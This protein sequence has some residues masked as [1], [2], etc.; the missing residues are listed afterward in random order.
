MD[1]ALLIRV[2]RALRAPIDGKDV[3]IGT[4]YPIGDERVLVARHVLADQERPIDLGDIELTWFY[5]P[6][7]NGKRVRADPLKIELVW[8]G[9]DDWDAAIIKCPFP[10]GVRFPGDLLRCTPP[11]TDER[12]VSRGFAA[13]GWR[14]DGQEPQPLKGSTYECAADDS[15]FHLGVDDAAQFAG[16]W[17]GISGAPVFVKGKIVGLIVNAYPPFG[18]RRVEAIPMSRLLKIPGFCKAIGLPSPTKRSINLERFASEIAKQ[19]LSAPRVIARVG[20]H[21]RRA[22]VAISRRPSPGGASTEQIWAETLAW[23]LID[24]PFLD[25]LEHLRSAIESCTTEPEEKE[26][27]ILFL[28]LCW[29]LPARYDQEKSEQ[30][31][32]MYEKGEVDLIDAHVAT[33]LAVELIVAA[34]EEREAQIDRDVAGL[35]KWAGKNCI[36]GQALPSGLGATREEELTKT[37]EGYLFAKFGAG[38]GYAGTPESYRRRVNNILERELR[39][40]RGLPYVLFGQAVD[41]SELNRAE[42]NALAKAIR[43]LYPRLAVLRLSNAPD[44][45][46]DEFEKLYSL[47]DILQRL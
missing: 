19:F 23:I 29:F 31:R 36:L 14:D 3:E 38:A 30:V 39:A 28:I 35:G 18:A 15:I 20:D 2:Y 7:I 46:E 43:S 12:W 25:A 41:Q 24:L 1:S 32:S 16:G 21:F 37:I 27:Q 10:D 6:R 9:G 22:H 33:A 17:K 34:M 11:N 5:Q 26:R 4:A 42:L 47:R 44:V 40:G 8:D 13:V 45:H